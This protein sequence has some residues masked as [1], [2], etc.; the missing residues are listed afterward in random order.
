MR[1]VSLKGSVLLWVLLS[2]PFSVFG[3]SDDEDVVGVDC[4]ALLVEG[5]L[6]G[7][8]SLVEDAVANGARLNQQLNDEGQTP[9]ALAQERLQE[10]GEGDQELR[11]AYEAIIA[12]LQ[13]AFAPSYVMYT[14]A[15]DDNGHYIMP[16]DNTGNA[17]ALGLD[18]RDINNLLMLI[19]GGSNYIFQ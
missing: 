5:I 8:T 3:Q 19:D 15:Y 7:N 13:R 9:L 17:L 10:V 18:Q 16:F 12:M 2:V 14:P 6:V 1:K 4:D 11:E